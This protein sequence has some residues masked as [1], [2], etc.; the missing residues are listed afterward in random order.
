MIGPGSDKNQESVKKYQK[1]KVTHPITI[2]PNQSQCQYIY[3]KYSRKMKV[4]I[5]TKNVTHHIDSQSRLV[6]KDMRRKKVKVKFIR[7]ACPIHWPFCKARQDKRVRINVNAPPILVV[8]QL[9]QGLWKAHQ[10]HNQ[11]VLYAEAISC[12]FFSPK[13]CS[14]LW[15]KLGG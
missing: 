8:K 13:S 15:L 11:K 7:K 12:V 9:K 14:P 6:L 2:T 3:H 10:W 4:P 5:N 1:V